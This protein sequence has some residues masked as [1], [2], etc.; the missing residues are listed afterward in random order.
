M[1]YIMHF[2]YE[3]CL[4]VLA[5]APVASDSPST[6]LLPVC[7]VCPV[8]FQ[9]CSPNKRRPLRFSTIPADIAVFFLRLISSSIS[10]PLDTP[11]PVFDRLIS[12]STKPGQISQI[13]PLS[14]WK[15]RLDTMR[16]RK[17]RLELE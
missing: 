13:H 7:R 4:N 5:F 11:T 6:A 2:V 12:V 16:G 10:L 14:S 15:C 1:W 8:T 9:L 3:N 17:G